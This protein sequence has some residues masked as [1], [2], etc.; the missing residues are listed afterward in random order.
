MSIYI[1]AKM[2]P[3]FGQFNQIRKDNYPFSTTFI[4]YLE[5]VCSL[6]LA[7]N[8][9]AD[10]LTGYL[11]DALIGEGRLPDIPEGDEPVVFRL[12][13]ENETIQA[14]LE[15]TTFT[16]RV[17]VLFIIRMTL[18]LSACY[19]TSLPR[20]ERLIR[21]IPVDD[22]EPQRVSEPPK[23][24]VRKKEPSPV[25]TRKKLAPSPADSM[26]SR[27]EALVEKGDR[28]LA[29]TAREEPEGTAVETNPLLSSFL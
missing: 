12:K 11:E 16:N 28:L 25:P 22:E 27:L 17:S 1:A 9:D 20:L 23:V 21:A 7:K 15:R 2:P 4:T 8:L 10:E 26:T 18:R 6:G 5:A 29:E 24:V 3:R 19:G 13:T 14:Y